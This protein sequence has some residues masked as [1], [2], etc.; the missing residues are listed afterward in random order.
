MSLHSSDSRSEKI[1]FKSLVCDFLFQTAVPLSSSHPPK[2]LKYYISDSE[3]AVIVTTLEFETK[4]KPI[5]DE[6]GLNVIY[7]DY[8]C[9]SSITPNSN[10]D[11]NPS[12]INQNFPSGQFY[13]NRNALILYTSGSTGLPKGVVLSH[14]NLQ[15]QTKCLTTIWQMQATDNMLHVLPLNHVHGC[16]IGLLGPLLV[17]GT[18]TILRKFNAADAWTKLLSK[19]IT[20]FTAVPTIY[21]M[22]IAEY[23]TKYAQNPESVDSIRQTCSAHIRLMIS[24]SASLPLTVFNR[25]H[26]ISGHKIL[27]RYGQTETGG[28]V[29]SN[30]YHM[31]AN[32]DR[33]PGH[34]G[35]VVPGISVRLVNDDKV[36]YEFTGEYGNEFWKSSTA[37][38]NTSD[39]S[40][41]NSTVTGEVFVKGPS[42]FVEYYKKETETKK[43]FT[44][45]RWF[46]TG[47]IATFANG[48]FKI[49]GRLSVDIIKTGGY[50]VSA[51]EI[52]SNLLEHPL[53]SDVCVIGVSDSKWGQ[54]VAALIVRK[55]DADATSPETD[56]LSLDELREW[57]R[58]RLAPY[59]IPTIVKQMEQIPRNMIGKPNKKEIVQ[60]LFPNTI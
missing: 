34:V 10:A 50:K 51:L 46:K 28:M 54:R 11:N 7:V 44:P 13:R 6:I 49:E 47:D 8:S 60:D 12:E 31:D 41:Q 17:G 32:R 37:T 48:V 27:E 59:Q 24:G 16:L 14:R 29:L 23:D 30:P 58:T 42:V 18:V 36:L 9:L 19:Q 53:I 52:E 40:H 26:H 45:D 3:A 5:A 56:P 35:D 38:L 25:W 15:M 20:L 43:D 21:T 22:L 2:L 1:T 57:C 39:G 4:L 33:K 55:P